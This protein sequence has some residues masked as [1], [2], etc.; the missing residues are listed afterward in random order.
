MPP[1][2]VRGPGDSVLGKHT[3]RKALEHV[4]ATLGYQLTKDQISRV[5]ER[6][7][8]EGEQ[9]SVITPDHLLELIQMARSGEEPD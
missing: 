8:S 9:K 4:V 7:K 5:L 6:V 1:S 2:L 3:G